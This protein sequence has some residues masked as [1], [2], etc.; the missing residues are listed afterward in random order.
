M[1]AGGASTPTH[2]AGNTRRSRDHLLLGMLRD[3]AV[4]ERGER[5]DGAL[6]SA[7]TVRWDAAA[8]LHLGRVACGQI[9]AVIDAERA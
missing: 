9:E 4:D 2:D 1:V 8:V 5:V 6:R 3:T 7:R